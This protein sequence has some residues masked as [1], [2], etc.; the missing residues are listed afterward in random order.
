MGKSLRVVAALAGFLAFQ[1][2]AQDMAVAQ[3][4]AAAKLVKYRVE[5]VHKGRVSVVYGDYEGKADVVDRL[6]VEFAW[7]VKKRKV[8]EPVTVADGKSELGNLR[9]DGTNCPPPTLK[10]DY[11]H[12]QS[13]S[14]SMVAGGQIQ[15]KGTRTFP[16]ASVSNYPGSCSMRSIP[17]GKEQATLWVGGAGPEILAAPVMAAG[18]VTIAADRK[19]F[20]MKGAENW[21]WTF[22]PTLVQ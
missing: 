2:G 21:V 15:I 5:G 7:D 17:G 16:A 11:E 20:S 22:T 4:W 8:V 12:F 6:T 1:S 13:V 10:G 19:S 14:H 3:K 9:S 18:P